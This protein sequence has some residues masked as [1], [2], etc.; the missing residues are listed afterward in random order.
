MMGDQNTS[1]P[2]D[3]DAP[4]Q[5]MKTNMKHVII[6]QSAICKHTRNRWP[7]HQRDKAYCCSNTQR[8]CTTRPDLIILQEHQL[9]EQ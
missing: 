5:Q 2:P 4:Q 8:T 9:V 3:H 7:N 1:H 6:Q